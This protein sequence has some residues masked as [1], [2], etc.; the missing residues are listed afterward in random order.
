MWPTCPQETYLTAFSEPLVANVPYYEESR[1]V[2]EGNG[3]SSSG[4][5]TSNLLL[6]PFFLLF[7]LKKPIKYAHVL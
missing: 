6:R 1:K 3:Y 7:F 4:T 2:P 5:T